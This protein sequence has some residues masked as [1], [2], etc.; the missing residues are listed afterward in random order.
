M[1]VRRTL[2]SSTFASPTSSVK[3]NLAQIRVQRQTNEQLRDLRLKGRVCHIINST[4]MVLSWLLALTAAARR[5]CHA[6]D[7]DDIAVD[8]DDEWSTTKSGFVGL[9]SIEI[10]TRLRLSCNVNN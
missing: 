4:M 3:L 7:T 10:C 6:D 8:F 2:S 5:H 9:M 1:F